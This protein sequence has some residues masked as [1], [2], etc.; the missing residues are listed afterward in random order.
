MRHAKL[1]LKNYFKIFT[2]EKN[3]SWYRPSAGFNVPLDK[4]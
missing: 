3:Q 4:M 1:I 2:Y